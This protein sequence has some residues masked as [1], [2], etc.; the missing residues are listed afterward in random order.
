MNIYR[1]I[2]HNESTIIYQTFYDI[3]Q[4]F[5]EH[6]MLIDM[7]LC[8]EFLTIVKTNENEE[9]LKIHYDTIFK[10]MKSIPI[11]RE[12]LDIYYRFIEQTSS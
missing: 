9:F 3:F 4:L 6:K 10:L 8:C 12:I 2:N 1:S 5:I 7:N 11:S